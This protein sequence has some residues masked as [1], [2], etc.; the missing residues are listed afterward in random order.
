MVM[1]KEKALYV[2]NEKGVLKP[3]VVPLEVDKDALGYE[4]YKDETIEIVPIPRLKLREIFD[5]VSKITSED[6]KVRDD[7][8]DRLFNHRIILEHCVNPKYT[9][10]E[11]KVM[12]PEIIG[13]I[14][15]TVLRESG[16]GNS[17]A[18]LKDGKE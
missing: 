5:N 2:T 14:V 10:E 7:E 8:H 13:I 17:K 16:L 18:E 6:A 4:L 1:K 12:K 11:L 9:E 15:N 3:K